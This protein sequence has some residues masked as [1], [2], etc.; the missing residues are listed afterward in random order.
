[1]ELSANT[2]KSLMDV[3]DIPVTCYALFCC[4]IKRKRCT[5][6]KFGL[7]ANLGTITWNFNI[8]KDQILFVS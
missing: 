6:T 2:L 7:Y 8:G 4:F 3:N 5:A 1:M